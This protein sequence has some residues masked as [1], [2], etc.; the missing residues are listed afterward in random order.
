MTRKKA[1]L[2]NPPSIEDFSK[3]AITK[4]VLKTTL[5]HPLSLYCSG[6]G[7]LGWLA[8]GVLGT[9]PVSVIA[10]IGGTAIGV[11]SWIVNFFMRGDTLAQKYIENI[12]QEMEEYKQRVTLRLV[13]DLETWKRLPGAGDYVSQGINQFQDIQEKIVNFRDVLGKK[14]NPQEM[15]FSRYLG[16]AEQVYLSVLDNLDKMSIILESISTIDVSYI[17]DRLQALRKLK[18]LT[19]ADEEEGKTLHERRKLRDDKLQ[20][21]N[22]LLTENEQAM[23]EIE[24]AT[25]SLVSITR[26]RATVDME[27]AR[28][29]LEELASR[30]HQYASNKM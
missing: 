7:L 2:S 16:S 17:E 12:Q 15:T 27:T 3:T 23:T 10:A 8:L 26:S 28:K 21:V 14:L 19:A 6:V 1:G 9:S 30:A 29:Q 11:G 20:E 18:T 25:V 5:Q 13:K 24:K 4:A 22:V